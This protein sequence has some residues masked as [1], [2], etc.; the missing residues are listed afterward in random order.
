METP[1]TKKSFAS[2]NHAGVHPAILQ[3]IIDANIGHEKAYG[4]DSYTKKAIELFKKHFGQDI[5]VYLV[6]T[7]T[8]ANVLGMSALLKPYQAILCPETAHINN[9]EAGAPERYTGSKILPV[10]T[11]D[12]K[13]TVGALK[14]QLNLIGVQH[15][16]QPKIIS[17]SQATELGTVYTPEEIKKLTDFAHKNNLYVHMDGARLCNAAARLNKTLAQLTKD[18]GIDLLAFGGTK[19]GMMIGEAVLF[20]NKELAKDFQYI[21]KQGMQLASKSRFI[22]AQF[23]P[24]LSNDLWLK[25][26]QHA[27]NMA[28]LLAEEMN[29]IPDIK[30]SRPVHAN[31]VFAYIDPALIPLLQE[32]YFFYVWNAATSEVRLMTSFDTTKED[33]LDFVEYIK[34]IKARAD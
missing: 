10:K 15:K 33:V 16:V 7:G 31:A 19:D 14:D 5:A 4:Q 17:I 6:L 34:A 3:A 21:R 25:N 28:T 26:A 20:F 32:R 22:A 27:N 24:F 8:A 13:L 12:G 9:D 11:T 30:T 2:D 29:K 23:I 1:M 18:V